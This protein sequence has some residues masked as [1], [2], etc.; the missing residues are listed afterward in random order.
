MSNGTAIPKIVVGDSAFPIRLER[1]MT[2]NQK[3]LP[4]PAK[5]LINKKFLPTL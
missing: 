5:K 1:K 2:V 3:T 4:A